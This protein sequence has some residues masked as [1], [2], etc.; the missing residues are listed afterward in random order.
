MF[1]ILDGLDDTK[2]DPNNLIEF[3]E[4]NDLDTDVFISQMSDLGY[5]TNNS[6]Q[7][8]GSMFF[9]ICFYFIRVFLIVFFHLASKYTGKGQE[10]LKN[11]KNRLFFNEL[12]LLL[13]EGYIHG[14][15]HIWVY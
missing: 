7:N 4:N 6:I 8:L 15:G 5:K 11:E 12:I 2:Y 3:D 1:D 9:I 14:V 13:V 10:A